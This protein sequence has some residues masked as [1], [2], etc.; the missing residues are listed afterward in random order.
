M[1]VRRL[2]DGV[3]PDDE[4][5]QAQSCQLRRD[6]TGPQWGVST[7]DANRKPPDQ[8]T[9]EHLAQRS[10]GQLVRHRGPQ[11][12]RELFADLRLPPQLQHAGD[13]RPT[14]VTRMLLQARKY[15]V[16]VDR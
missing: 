11:E 10:L 3:N 12:G 8:F 4:S 14:L 16:R 1:I 9:S 15:G 7:S 5:G 2:N 6:Q 13:L